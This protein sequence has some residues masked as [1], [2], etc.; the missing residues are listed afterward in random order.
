MKRWTWSSVIAS[1]VLVLILLSSGLSTSAAPGEQDRTPAQIEPALQEVL[2]TQGQANLFVILGNLPDLS[3]AYQ[4][5]WEKRGEFVYR[6]LLEHANASQ[7]PLR[8]FLDAQR[9]PYRSFIIDNSIYIPNATVDL[10]NQLVTFPGVQ[11]LRLEQVY[12]V[13]DV[14]VEPEQPGITAVEWGVAKINA[15]DVW[16]LGYTGQG[17]VVAN[18]DTGVRYTHNALKNQYRGNLGG[19]SYDHT[20]SWYDPTG[21]YPSAPGDN[22]GHGTH[23]MGTI[24]GDDGG[25]NQIGVAPGARWIACKGCTNTSCPD[26]ALNACADWLLAPGGESS[27]RPHLVNNSW[28]GCSYSDWYRSKV[29]AWLAAGIYPVFSAG[30]TSN[31][32]Y[33][34]AFCGSV[35]TPATYKE[36]TAV[37][38]TTSSDD[39]S[40]FSLWGPSQDPTAP[41]EIKPEV[42]APGSSIRSASYSSDT[43]YTTMSGTSMAA[44]HVS[45]ALAL[46]WSACPSLVGNL[47]STEQLL[48]DTAVKIAYA[49]GCGN[50][51]PGNI[52]NNAFGYGR[53]DV[54]AAVNA[55]YNPGPTPTPTRTPTPAPVPPILLVDDDNGSAYESYYTAA[56]NA[57]GKSYDLWTVQSQ[58]SPSAATLQQYNIVIWFTGSDW[59]TTLT[60]T[61]QSNLATYLDGAGRLFITGQDIGY[62]IRS[63]AFYG[64]Y[65]H[66]SYIN[67][68]TNTYGLTGY[69]IMAGVNISISG[70]DGAGNQNYPSEIGL[71]SGAVGLFD[72]DGSYT[73]G[74][75]R[76]EGTY[77]LVYF[78]FGFEAISSASSRSTVMDKVLTWLEGGAPPPTSTPVPPTPTPI[79]PTNTPLPTNTPV[80][81]T[82]TPVPPTPT[83]PPGGG[84]PLPFY[85]GFE[86][87]SL[88]AY[89]S[90]HATN[91]G[92][93]R[94]STSYP[95]AGSYS[96]LLDDSVSGGNYS[97]AGVILTVD[98]AG[99]SNVAL[100]FWWR[101]FSDE[102]HSGDGVLISDDG[103][104]SWC[105]V[106]S[107][108]NGPNSYRNDVI[109]LDAAAASCGMSFNGAFQIKFQ[110]YDNYPI[111]SDG[112]AIDDVRVE[113]VGGAP[114]PTPAPGGI[115]LVDDDQGSVYE[116]YYTAALNALGYSYD[117]WTVSTQGSPSLATLQQYSV[118]IWFT[119]DDYTNTLTGT[120]QS[121][122]GAY[123]DG[124]G[125]LFITGQDIGYDI[126]SDAFY[127]NYLHASYVLD[128]TNTYDLSGADLF[129]GVNISISGGDGANNQGYPSEIGP[130]NGAWGVFDYAGSYTWGGLAVDTG[131]Y[132]LIYFSFGFE[133]INSASARNAVM[134]SALTWLY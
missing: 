100:D 78:S 81:P 80:P 54:L 31:C 65:L 70:G 53:I 28:G 92:R 9:I 16:G 30:N 79:P 18:I 118:V 35:G 108:N 132:R 96:V 17:I 1:V 77:R 94:V 98:L 6:T 125:H 91:Q 69:D 73:W 19:G 123:L 56:L 116:T 33:S 66:A 106:L 60:S 41:N 122:L 112:Y 126:R 121:N 44:P 37:G 22:N 39:I 46:I 72:Y 23:T 128:D 57:L 133:A 51:G 48:K 95:H 45:G 87:G 7:A 83:P 120:D 10:V 20:Y 114:T 42:S 12:P 76:W 63:D 119:G 93:I 84:A 134:S 2:D 97:E 55:C 86:S 61:D 13:P 34:S 59:S 85:D 11:M 15:D 8:A 50:E 47:D 25:S 117:L 74:G 130:I 40:S 131:T 107:F 24:I 52:P 104:V 64:N 124:G 75:L 26:S 103:G 5:S 27:K 111:S 36:V 115:L 38:S 4:M 21:T 14:K 109:D 82:N 88:G 68:D 67:D 99:Q 43:G 62:D 90:T 58:G 113:A 29:N 129:A 105:Q 127:G 32:G 71:G 110:F 3:P 101:E 89:W 102:N 49:T